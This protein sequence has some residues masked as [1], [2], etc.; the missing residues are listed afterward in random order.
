MTREQAHAKMREEF[1]SPPPVDSGKRSAK[2]DGWTFS[3][4]WVM[5]KVLDA[6]EIIDLTDR[7]GYDSRMSV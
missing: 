3:E 7:V 5:I 4:M 1:E 2:N 6:G